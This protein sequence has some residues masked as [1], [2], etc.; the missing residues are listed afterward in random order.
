MSPSASCLTIAGSTFP[1]RFLIMQDDGNLVI[2]DPDRP[3]WGS[4]WGANPFPP[5]PSP[6]AS[7]NFT[8]DGKLEMITS[9]GKAVH[10]IANYTGTPAT[11]RWCG[12][13]GTSPE[14]TGGELLVFSDGNLVLYGGD[15]WRA[16]WVSNSTLGKCPPAPAPGNKCTGSSTQLPAEQCSAWIDFY[17]A[18]G[19]LNWAVCAGSRTDPCSCNTGPLQRITCSSDGTAVEQL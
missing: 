5:L 14:S 10:N 7:F 11:A 9:D 2:Y 15:P 1:N 18:L 8:N 6:A 12:G 13:D 19:G 17:D 4:V 3:V 16:L